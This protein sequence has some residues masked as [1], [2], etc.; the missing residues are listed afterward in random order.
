[1]QGN[2]FALQNRIPAPAAEPPDTIAVLRTAYAVPLMSDCDRHFNLVGGSLRGCLLFVFLLLRSLCLVTIHLCG[3]QRHGEHIAARA[4]I[5]HRYH[6]IHAIGGNADHGGG[7]RQR[8]GGKVNNRHDLQPP[9]NGQQHIKEINQRN[10]QRR[11]Q[12]RHQQISVRQDRFAEEQRQP[13]APQQRRTD[14]HADR[15]PEDT[16]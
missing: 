14:E 3:G 11:S 6:T 12:H 13:P 5:Q 4:E 8:H 15:E 10:A 1:M 7:H 2:D 9:S 16:R